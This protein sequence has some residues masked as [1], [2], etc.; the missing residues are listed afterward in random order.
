MRFILLKLAAY[1]RNRDRVDAQSGIN[2]GRVQ[3]DIINQNAEF[4]DRS[5]KVL[6][7]CG[8]FELKVYLKVV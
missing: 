6:K 2:I 3:F 5:D 4:S 7:I 8:F 1:D